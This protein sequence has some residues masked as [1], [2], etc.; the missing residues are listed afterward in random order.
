MQ[1]TDDKRLDELFKREWN[2]D[3][4]MSPE[5]ATFMG[6]HK[7]NDRL[8]D[9]SFESTKKYND[10]EKDLLQ[11]LKGFDQDSLSE[12]NKINL[13]LFL[14]K[15]Q[16]SLNSFEFQEYLMPLNQMYGVQTSFSRMVLMSPF[17]K[18]SDYQNY[19]SRLNAFP[20]YI[21]QTISLLD[22]GIK[23]GFTI[24]KIAMAD[25]PNQISRQLVDDYKKSTFYQPLNKE[26]LPIDDQLKN[27]IENAIQNKLYTSFE[28]LKKYLLDVYIPNCRDSLGMSELPK[29][30]DFYNEKLSFFTTTKLTAEEIHDIGIKE[31]KRIFAEMMVLIKTLGFTDYSKFLDHLR[32]NPDFY[33]K[34]EKD[35]LIH[36]RDFAKRIDKEL[37]AFFKVLP[38][39]TYGVEKI[40]DHQAPSC[41]TAYYMGS[42]MDMTRAGIFYANTYQLETRPKYEMEALTLHEAVPGHHLQISLALEL[43]DLPDFRKSARFIGY[44]EG[45]A[46]YTEKLG[47]E[48]GF[49]TDPYARFGQLSFEIW[50]AC[51]LVVDTGLHVFNWTRDK[52]IEYLQYY[53]GKNKDAC[54]VEVDR[55]IVMPGQATSYKIGELKIL[56]LRKKFED[57]QG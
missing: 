40:P 15:L 9:I 29:G 38:R 34:D 53:T 50:R 23:T 43:S 39:L 36:Y 4:E 51:R 1:T 41:P 31:V 55:Y 24:P 2:H 25:V 44:I 54:A 52:S 17:V 45:W 19:L 13:K 5:Y 11:E 18:E 47:A 16:N 8:S 57:V 42:D 6:E 14:F 7:Y 49:Y 26:K 35:L 33:F 48:M 46:L 30:K 28:K 32:T 22:E 37:P 27:E 3:F 21:D 12:T 10:Y 56:E 20:N